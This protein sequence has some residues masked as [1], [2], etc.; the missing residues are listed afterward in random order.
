MRSLSVA[1]ETIHNWAARHL[2]YGLFSGPQFTAPCPLLI[3]FVIKLIDL[4]I[5]LLPYLM[6]KYVK[7][8]TRLPLVSKSLGAILSYPN[9]AGLSGGACQTTRPESDLDHKKTAD[10]KSADRSAP[11]QS[12]Y[13]QPEQTV[14]HKSCELFH[15]QWSS[16]KFIGAR[17]R[18]I[19]VNYFTYVGPQDR[20]IG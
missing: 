18:T 7:L 3:L 5:I 8:F 16:R 12:F 13:S 10:M 1:C 9:S 4:K 14:K 20:I 19:H 15:I 17:R 11:G 2:I 6:L